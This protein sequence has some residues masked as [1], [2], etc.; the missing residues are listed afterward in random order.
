MVR[1][2]S[3][4][5][6]EQV[7]M[8]VLL[9]ELAASACGSFQA[10]AHGSAPLPTTVTDGAPTL[11][12]L[13]V[14]YDCADADSA[15]KSN[16]PGFIEHF[17]TTRDLVVDASSFRTCGKVRRLAVRDTLR[18]YVI[19]MNPFCVSSIPSL[20]R[21]RRSPKRHRQRFSKP[22]GSIFPQS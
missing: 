13:P 20:P 21:R 17:D 22:P 5:G 16:H 3:R 15:F 14:P 12:R 6:V 4:C 9:V 11:P 18:L 1:S 7:L 2:K 19:N 8:V 10:R